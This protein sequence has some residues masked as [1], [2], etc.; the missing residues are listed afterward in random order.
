MRP[1]RSFSIPILLLGCLGLYGCGSDA[2]TPPRLDAAVDTKQPTPD[3][4]VATPD[5]NVP[6]PDTSIVAPDTSVATLDTGTALDTGAGVLDTSTALDTGAGALDTGA[7]GLDTGAGAIDG[8]GTT[9]PIRG[10]AAVHS[11]YQSSAVSLLDR[12]GKVLKD[13]CINSGT[14]SP[15]L[16]MTLSGDVVLPSQIAAT[17]AIALVDRG[18]STLTWIDPTTCA[19]LRQLA[20]GTGFKANPHDYVE[21]SAS[22]AYVTRYEKNSAA[23]AVAFDGGN[24]LLIVDPS[25]PKIVGRI[26]LGPSAPTGVLPRADRALLVN[27]KVYV[28]LNASDAKYGANATGRL[29]VV[30]PALDQVTSTL[31]LPGTKNCGALAYLPADKKLLVA[32]NGDYGDGSKQAASSGVVTL[33]LGVS[34]PAIAALV[35]GTAVGNLVFSNLTVAALDAESVLGVTIGDF[36]NVPPDILWLLP[37]D[38]TTPSQI[39]SSAEA[40]S[41]GAVLVDAERSR[42]F[43][44]DGTTTSAPFLR[45]F[46]RV[47][48][49]FRTTATINT[50]PTQ[51]LPARALA[52]F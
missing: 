26:D 30:D 43:L 15:G 12:D 14:G 21:L 38:R 44:A 33:D 17:S 8:G 18:Y 7:S 22:K 50:N 28:A 46:E 45:V 52:W 25:R 23:G 29:V 11:D 47:S 48:G 41:L 36:S 13:G 10:I 40:Y 27:G 2:G 34:P 39:F 20:V 37:Q 24:D 51:K 9:T 5:T 4:N 42:V 1:S 16:S 6:P 32:C 35:T 31:D 49:A 3:T 19:P